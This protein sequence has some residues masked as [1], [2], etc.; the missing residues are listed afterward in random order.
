MNKRQKPIVLYEG[1][2]TEEDLEKLK[3]EMSV[4]KICDIY[5]GQLEELFEIDNP[6][7]KKKSGYKTEMEK[8]VEERI[9]PK[10]TLVGNWIYFPWNGR[11]VHSV[12][13]KEYL[14][15]RTNRNKNLITAEEQEKLSA[16]TVG[17][18][19]LSVGSHI[20][21]NLTYGGVGN[22]MKLAEYDTLDTTNLNRIR[23]RIDEIE[24]PK[25]NIT[26]RQIYE[27]NPYADLVLFNQGITDEN[28]DEFVFQEPAPKIIFEIIDNFE[29]KIKLRLKAKKARIPVAMF[30]NIGDRILFDIE[31][32]DLDG[33]LPLFNG[34]A[35][36]AP[37][38]I[39]KHPDLTDEDK[40]KYAVSLTGIENIPQRALDSVKEIDK[41][42]VGRPQLMSTVSITGGLAAYITKQIALGKP[43]PS[44]RK[45]VKFRDLFY[46]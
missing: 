7:L 16:F 6:K 25:I 4:W 43:I 38:E 14:Q 13:K 32:Y 30:A 36:S 40:N 29:M 44:G 9:S 15:L 31:R 33:N 8:F 35:G 17:M 24:E 23:A 28:L 22:T 21:L 46:Y 10:Q 37:E 34:L 11:L 3:K 19:G 42:L 27:V 26:A 39:I 2:N 45:L 41:T 18:L 1:K 12:N 20:A 5:K